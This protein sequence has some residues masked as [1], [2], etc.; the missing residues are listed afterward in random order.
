MVWSVWWWYG[1]WCGPDGMVFWV[2]LGRAL[3][4]EYRRLLL[5]WSDVGMLWEGFERG[6]HAIIIRWVGGMVYGMV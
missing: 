4:E 6:I 3:I 1:I 5:D 2:A